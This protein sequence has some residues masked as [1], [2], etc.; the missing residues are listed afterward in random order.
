MRH[1]Q[2]PRKLRCARKRCAWDT[3]HAQPAA[4]LSWQGAASPP[5]HPPDRS[6]A[7]GPHQTRFAF[8][9]SDRGDFISPWTLDR[10]RLRS[11]PD[12]HR[13]GV[14]RPGPARGF[15]TL[16]R[17]R[18]FAPWTSTRSVPP[19]DPGPTLRGLDARTNRIRQCAGR[20]AGCGVRLPYGRMAERRLARNEQRQPET[21]RHKTHQG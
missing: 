1:L 4:S 15:C 9:T 12:P 14:C 10:W 3:R 21:S 19:R 13:P 20:M 18:A 8:W 11:P 6:V 2:R 7:P 17:T 16:D 5:L